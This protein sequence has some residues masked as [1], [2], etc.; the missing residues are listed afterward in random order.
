MIKI[1]EFKGKSFQIEYVDT[2]A[3]HPTWYSHEDERDVREAFW[4]PGK[5]DIVLD[6]GACVGSYTLPALAHGACVYAWAPGKLQEGTLETELIR[7]SVRLNEGF[8]ER[9]ILFPTGLYSAPG[10]LNTKTLEFRTRYSCGDEEDWLNVFTLDSLGLHPSWMKLDVEGVELEVLKGGIETIKRARPKILTECHLNV[11]P[12][13][14]ASVDSFLTTYIG[15]YR[16]VGEIVHPA[17]NV[18]HTFHVP[19]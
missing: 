14:S 6:I 1:L 3:T 10:A 8:K 12:S 19:V 2:Y 11:D 16:L 5:G 4:N 18:V 7:Y 15:G 9:L 13:L 17:S